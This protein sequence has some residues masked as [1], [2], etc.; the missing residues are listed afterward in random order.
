M[1]D[2][3]APLASSSSYPELV[4]RGFTAG[5]LVVA[6]FWAGMHNDLVFAVLTQTWQKI[7]LALGLNAA[8]A[9][10]QS[11]VSTLVTTRS[12]PAVFTYSLVYTAACLGILY[13]ALYDAARMRL[14]VQ[15]YAAVFAAC[16]LLLLGGKLLGDASWA[17]QLGRRLIDFIVSPLPVIILV[18]LLRWYGTQTATTRR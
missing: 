14:V 5:L 1:P 4:V 17:Y 8:A 15:L 7:F 12:L 9:G 6:L 16:A 11:G 2:T 13:A 10:P 18:P 3:A